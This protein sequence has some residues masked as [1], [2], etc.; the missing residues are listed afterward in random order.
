MC[1]KRRMSS[2]C[3]YVKTVVQE[4]K[5]TAIA[6]NVT[7][8]TVI[9]GAGLKATPGL[10]CLDHDLDVIQIRCNSGDE[11]AMTA[12]Q[13]GRTDIYPLRKICKS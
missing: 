2:I 4:Q 9:L 10:V 1:G 12:L 11:N 7:W 3:L 8:S 13:S 6:G 5:D